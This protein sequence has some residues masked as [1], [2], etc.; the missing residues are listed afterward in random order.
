[1][2]EHDTDARMLRNI[3]QALQA[4]PSLRTKNPVSRR[5][6]A[7]AL[8]ALGVT[9]CRA[10]GVEERELQSIVSEGAPS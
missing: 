6:F 2:K 8:L 10:Y 5:S 4:S 3:S 1:M 9:A 7:R